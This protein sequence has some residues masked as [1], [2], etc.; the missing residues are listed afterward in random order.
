MQ[1]FVF[2]TSK[3][4]NILTAKGLPCVMITAITDKD[5]KAIPLSDRAQLGKTP[6]LFGAVKVIATE[7]QALV[8][9]NNG[10]FMAEQTEKGWALRIEASVETE[11]ETPA[12]TKA[13]KAGK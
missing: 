6:H 11:E 2:L 8:A 9:E 5:L 10:H 4:T 12:V 13:I 7:G 3:P 1:K